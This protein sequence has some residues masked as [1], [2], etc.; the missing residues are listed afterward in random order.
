MTPASPNSWQDLF[1]A[2]EGHQQVVRL[3][4]RLLRRA[5][6]PFL[7]LP[8]QPRAAAATLDLY[9]AQTPR[10]RAARS[11]L[12]CLLQASLPLG[13]E[14]TSLS[15]S[16]I[17]PF[18]KFLSSF[19]GEPTQGV[20]TFG[21]LAGNPM[22]DG[23][24][25]LL[26]VSDAILQPVAVIKAGLSQRAKALIAREAAFLT[27]APPNTK[28]VPGLRAQFE[29]TQLR[30]LA[31]D[32]FP[33]DPPRP[34]HE[35]AL[36]ALLASW[37]DPRQNLVVSDAP[38]WIR[39]EQAATA[40]PLFV[41]LAGQLHGRTV[42]PAIHHGDFAPWNIKVSPA[43]AW[44]VLDWERSELAGI[45]GWD[46]FHYVIQTGIL[47]ARLPIPPLVQR[48]ETL[49]ASDAFK[50]YASC[51]GISGCERELLLAYLLHAIEV[52]KPSEGLAAT[53]EL[54]NAFSARWGKP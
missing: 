54:L 45:P 31:L 41:F 5:G 9:P 43:G 53:A 51:A 34:Q 4:L 28:A 22:T 29:S 49:L 48:V 10:A 16:P 35:A 26:L 30:A 36:P 52:N 25:F 8:R 23:Q 40:K 39:L 11:V 14:R 32:F 13:T 7:L 38:D 27:A 44:T 1:T 46:W 15:L 42:H 18:V 6:R 17:D 47:V 3:E 50:Q 24:R 21:I 37:V 12:R 2:L 20:P 19:A 33:G